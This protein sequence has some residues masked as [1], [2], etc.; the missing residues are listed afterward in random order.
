MSKGF[1]P[2][3]QLQKKERSS[4]LQE[5]KSIE[6][7]QENLLSYIDHIQDPRVARTQKHLLKDII[8]IGILA[9][10]GGGEG[11]EAE[12]LNVKNNV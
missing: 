10:I 12:M 1:A 2:Q 11:W 7:V 6:E 5:L 4:Q 9:I 8:V 3:V